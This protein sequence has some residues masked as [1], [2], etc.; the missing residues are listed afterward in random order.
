MQKI[1]IIVFY[2][3]GTKFKDKQTTFGPPE[4]SCGGLVPSSILMEKLSTKSGV[5]IKQT[6]VYFLEISTSEPE[7]QCS[8]ICVTK[9]S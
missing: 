9:E 7:K 6:F 1:R 4:A 2:C 5:S 8:L 3:F